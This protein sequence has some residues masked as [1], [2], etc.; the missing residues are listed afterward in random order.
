MHPPVA[1]ADYYLPSYCLSIYCMSSAGRPVRDGG[2]VEPDV[3][4]P[5][6]K[7]GPSQVLLQPPLSSLL[8]RGFAGHRQPP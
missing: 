1:I 4:V 5:A 2:G 7:D 3:T 8:F 6:I